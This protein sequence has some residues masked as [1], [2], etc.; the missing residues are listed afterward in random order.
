MKT[1]KK[2]NGI[3]HFKI[4]KEFLGKRLLIDLNDQKYECTTTMPVSP[5]SIEEG[6][7]EIVVRVKDNPHSASPTK[8]FD[9]E[10]NHHYIFKCDMNDSIIELEISDY[11]AALWTE[12]AQNKK[13]A[14]ENC[15]KKLDSLVGL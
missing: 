12:I 14:I 5:F 15:L 1:G 3:I 6:R 2:R 8:I 13:I 4:G 11:D 7:Y 9:F 10:A